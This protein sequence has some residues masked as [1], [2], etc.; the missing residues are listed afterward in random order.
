MESVE[1]EF[2]VKYGKSAERECGLE[3]STGSVDED[4]KIRWMRLYGTECGVLRRVCSVA[5]KVGLVSVVCREKMPTVF[6]HTLNTN[7]CTCIM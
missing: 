2:G 7:T 5:W 1:E 6:V 3:V 4:Y